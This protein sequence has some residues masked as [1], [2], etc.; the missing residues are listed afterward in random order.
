MYVVWQAT[1]S[2]DVSAFICFPHTLFHFSAL[3][4]YPHRYTYISIWQQQNKNV[5][6][7]FL[8]SVSFSATH[9]YDMIHI[10]LRQ[11]VSVYVTSQTVI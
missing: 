2:T 5:Q 3:I 4:L 11:T 10:C 6:D 7:V 9:P 1:S 8:P